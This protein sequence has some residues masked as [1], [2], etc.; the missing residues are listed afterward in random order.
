M[1]QLRAV[2]LAFSPDERAG[3]FVVCGGEVLDRLPELFGT[4]K[5]G[6]RQ[7]HPAAARLNITGG[8]FPSLKRRFFVDAEAQRISGRFQGKADNIGRFG[9]KLR[10][11][12]DAPR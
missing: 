3:M 1:S 8:P 9:G 12:A 5:A 7:G 6:A 11:G 4:V 10:V 2:D